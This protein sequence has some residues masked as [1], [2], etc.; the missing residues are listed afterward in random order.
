MDNSKS[1]NGKLVPLLLI[2]IVAILLV[3]QVYP[4]YR[5]KGDC[6]RVVNQTL[7]KKAPDEY[8]K[9]NYDICTKFY[10]AE[11]WAYVFKIPTDK[12]IDYNSVVNAVEEVLRNKSY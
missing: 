2:I 5:I 6:D 4:R 11:E 3:Y 12:P 7:D 8:K 10:S 1:S 9:Q